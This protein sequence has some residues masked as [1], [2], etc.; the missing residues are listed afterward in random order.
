MTFA[1]L[2][3][4]QGLRGE[5]GD[6]SGGLLA[7]TVCDES[8]WNSA[9]W[10][11]HVIL[12]TILWAR[13]LGMLGCTVLTWGSAQG[14]GQVSHGAASSEGFSRLDAHDGSVPWPSSA[15][16][17]PPC[18]WGFSQRGGQGRVP[19]RTAGTVPQRPAEATHPA[20]KHTATLPLHSAAIK[21]V[22]KAS[23][24]SGGRKLDPTSQCVAW[25]EIHSCL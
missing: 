19:G 3:C 20:W 8:P 7:A 16:A 15:P 21:Q 25:L 17:G 18:G 24:D 22:T 4:L 6:W 1:G 14:C 11:D 23:P 9:A 12:L 2:L 5:L 13:H 10:N